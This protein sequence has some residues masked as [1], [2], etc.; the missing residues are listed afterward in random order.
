MY[1]NRGVGRR[2]I[3]FP[4]QWC[5]EA[6]VNIFQFSKGD[7][8]KESEKKRVRDRGR[9]DRGRKISKERSKEKTAVAE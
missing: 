2:C 8:R 3:R 1:Y 7:G 9:D 6:V 5:S 4:C